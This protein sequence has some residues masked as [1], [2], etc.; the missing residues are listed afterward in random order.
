MKKRASGEGTIYRRGSTWR[1]QL[2]I[3]GQRI[4][5]TGRT[6]TDVADQMAAARTDYNRG[7]YVQSNNI[8]V[9]KWIKIWL[10]QKMRPKLAEQSL[11]RL[12][13]LLNNHLLPALGKYKLQELTPF[14][15][16]QKYA[17]IFFKKTGKNYKEDTYSHSTVNSLAAS[18]KKCLQYAVMVVIK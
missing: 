5:F 4:S 2:T 6:K 9:E 8:T 16:E 12:E 3:N 1:G 14:L 15:L 7:N 17:E 10:N 11:I 18:F 13:G